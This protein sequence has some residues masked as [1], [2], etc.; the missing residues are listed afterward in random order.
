RS[1][2][3]AKVLRGLHFTWRKPQAQLVW[4]VEGAIFDVAVDLRRGSPKF[5]TWFGRVLSAERQEQLFMPPGFAHG[6]CVLS[7]HAAVHYKCSEEFD[8]ED[9]A[10]LHWRDPRLA[11]RWP[12]ADPIVSAR[13]AALPTLD[14]LPTERLPQGPFFHK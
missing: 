12:I 13:D 7:P 2:S 6:F 8:P 5:A 11:I 14:D 10:G 1:Y 3:E 4:V 9:D